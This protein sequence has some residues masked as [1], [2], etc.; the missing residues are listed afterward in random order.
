MRWEP[1][2][3]P[4]GRAY[5]LNHLHPLRYQVEL[6]PQNGRPGLD[7][8]V[9]VGFAMHCFTRDLVHNDPEDLHYRDDRECRAF[10]FDRYDLSHRLPEIARTLPQRTCQFAKN[11]NYVTLDHLTPDG[12]VITYGAFFNV[13]RQAADTVMLVFQSA[14]AIDSDP[15]RQPPGKG[16]IGLRVLLGHA[17]RGTKPKRP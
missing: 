2:Q 1:Y 10:C 6:P 4:G 16:K 13:K 14:Y 3:A 11:E 12:S 7:V 9:N 8:W 15:K 17:L 5:P